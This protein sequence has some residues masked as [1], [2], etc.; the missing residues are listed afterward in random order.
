MK[1]KRAYLGKKLV[2]GIGFLLVLVY[3]LTHFAKFLIK[4]W[5]G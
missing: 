2:F 4:N 1:L 5:G 3:E